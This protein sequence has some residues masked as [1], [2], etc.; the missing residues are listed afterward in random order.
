MLFFSRRIGLSGDSNATPVPILA[1]GRVTG[2]VGPYAIG[3]LNI[4]QQAQGTSPAT[5]FTAVRVQ[6]NV[7]ANSDVGMIVL[8]TA[9]AGR[10][11][12]VAGADANFLFHQN[13]NVSGYLVRS[14][15][16][17]TID[18]GTG[19]DWF[20]QIGY[21]YPTAHFDSTTTFTTI[22]SRFDDQLG[23][24]PLAGVDKVQ[25]RT[26]WHFRPVRTYGWL[27]E[28]FPHTH[29][30]NITRP[31]QGF[32]SRYVDYHLPFT[33]QNST[34]LEVGINT[35]R[36]RL[37]RPFLIDSRRGITVPAGLYDRR[38]PFVKFTTNPGAPLSVNA[39]Y[40]AG[41]FYGGYEHSY[42]AGGTLRTSARLNAGLQWTRDVV[43]LPAGSFTTDLVSTNVD[44]N[45]STHA[46]LNALIQYNTDT[47][48]WSANV[49]FDI[50][51]RPLSDLFIV[52]NDQ[53]DAITG[54]L[55][56]R[57]LVTKLTYLM[58]F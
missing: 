2:H 14:F 53:R 51:Y 33:F 48:Q 8:N 18:P 39:E 46:F 21:Y 37:Q 5:N 55:I 12:A 22:G 23:F 47:E 40:L 25:G 17:Q 10:N 32:Y 3:A 45:F 42:T 49:R 29:Y 9:G 58:A 35:S 57:A 27:R 41:P 20:G 56:G 36:E 7:L 54:D 31:G 28:I 19:H 26:G 11:N 6:R 30:T 13:L 34:S 52:Y 38:D 1:G 15:S 24:L 44:Y 16:S 50:I 43:A 4:E